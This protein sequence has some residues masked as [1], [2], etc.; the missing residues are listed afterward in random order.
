LI[1]RRDWLF[2]DDAYHIDVSHLSATVRVS[3]LLTDPAATALAAELAEYGRHLSHRHRFEG[4]PPFE[5]V[6]ADHAVYLNALLGK[7]TEEALT[8]FRAKMTPPA[9]AA[10]A[11]EADFD[12]Y[13]RPFD[14]APAAQV[15]VGLLVRLGRLDEAIEVAATH[16]AGIPEGSL[17]CPGVSQLCQR[18]GRPDRLARIARDKGDLVNFAAARL[19]SAPAGRREA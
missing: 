5:D 10:P 15:L 4:E 14:P 2:A 3:P 19:Q 1:E 9:D 7:D 11:A 12:E 16:L 13:E 18:A 8:H 6:Y 17:F